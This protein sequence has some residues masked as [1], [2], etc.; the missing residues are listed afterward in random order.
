MNQRIRI[1]FA[2][3][4]AMRYT[5]HLDL[6]RTW[7]RVFRRARLPLAYSQGF[8]PHPRLNLAAALPLGFTSDCEML[9]AWLEREMN[10][11][12]VQAALTPA[13]PPGIQ[14]LSLQIVE[15]NPPALQTL[16]A[17]ADYELT[18]LEPVPDLDSRLAELLAS[19]SLPRVRR[20]KPYDL[21]ALIETL[22]RIPDDEHGHARLRMRLSAKESAT[23]RPEEVLDVLGIA[24][25]HARAHRTHLLFQPLPVK[26]NE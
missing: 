9:D 25:H 12:E 24:A 1:T 5:G 7:E 6:H 13:L 18:L 11:D 23:G 22:E 8:S 19:P 4:A 17:S 14:I 10:L 16:V 3:T 20:D 2:K 15:G 21:R 26:E